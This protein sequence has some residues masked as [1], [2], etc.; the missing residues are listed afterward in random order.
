MQTR[1][2]VMYRLD[3]VH[4]AVA[5]ECVHAHGED[6]EHDTRENE[7]RVRLVLLYRLNVVPHR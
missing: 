6:D 4:V 7:V 1:H 5:T 2:H 3:Y